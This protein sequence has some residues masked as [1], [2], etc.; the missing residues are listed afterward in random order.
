MKL[1]VVNTSGDAVREIDVDDAVFGVEPNL[2]VVHQAL[3][4]QQANRRRG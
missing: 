2:G 3:L 4:A 1:S